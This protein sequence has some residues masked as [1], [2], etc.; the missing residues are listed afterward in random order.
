M[1]HLFS[2]QV[3]YSSR[4]GRDIWLDLALVKSQRCTN[5]AKPKR[6]L[7]QNHIPQKKAKIGKSK[8]NE[9][10]PILFPK[11]FFDKVLV[12]YPSTPMYLDKGGAVLPCR[13]Q[14]KDSVEWTNWPWNWMALKRATYTLP[15]VVS[16]E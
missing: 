9:K 1:R 15:R 6:S 13:L 8:D 4:H 11:D 2:L 10:G 16:L 3:S 7:K 5:G 14:D 12:P